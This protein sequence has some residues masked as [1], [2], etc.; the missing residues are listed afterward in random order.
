[1][2]P[3]VLA[4]FRFDTA[5]NEPAKNLQ[6]HFQNLPILL[7][8]LA[9]PPAPHVALPGLV[10]AADVARVHG[11]RLRL[12]EVHQ[13]REDLER[14]RILKRAPLPNVKPRCSILEMFDSGI[15]FSK[16]EW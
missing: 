11:E 12:G 14:E 9:A 2:L 15:C 6:K 5:E 8:L 16:S 4:Q 10:Q 7:I 13:H 1:M 3:N